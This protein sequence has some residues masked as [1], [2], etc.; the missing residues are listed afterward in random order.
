MPP[1]VPVPEKQVSNTNLKPNI[2]LV[3]KAP[4]PKADPPKQSPKTVPDTKPEVKEIKREPEEVKVD[5]KPEPNIAEPPKE[6]AEEKPPSPK[7]NANQ[8]LE[9]I[10]K[11]NSEHSSQS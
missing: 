7:L 10:Q 6:V 11:Q 9:D 4:S 1:P 8:W 2:E 3:K 5:P